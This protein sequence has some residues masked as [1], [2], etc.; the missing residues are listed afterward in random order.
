MTLHEKSNIYGSI[1]VIIITFIVGIIL[2]QTALPLLDYNSYNKE[3]CY[4]Q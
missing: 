2:L 3:I 4:I 1:F